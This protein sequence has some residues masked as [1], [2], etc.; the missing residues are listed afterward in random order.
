VSIN[1]GG[2]N[3]GSCT[4][5]FI[6]DFDG[7]KFSSET[8]KEDTLW[9]D[10]GP[11]NYA[12]VTW[13][14]ISANDGRRLFLGWMSNWSYAT[15]VPT[16][17]WR[18]AMTVPRELRLTKVNS[19]YYVSS[20]PAKELNNIVTDR[21]ENTSITVTDTLDLT[22][23]LGFDPSLSWIDIEMD[24][25]DF[26]IELSNTKGEKASISYDASKREYSFN[27]IGSGKTDFSSEF[28]RVS[29]APRINA[30]D[31]IKFSMIT[32][33]SSVEIFFDGGLTNLTGLFFPDEPF[34]RYRIISRGSLLIDRL[35]GRKLRSVWETSNTR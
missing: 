27:R 30:S 8:P 25:K 20:T 34:T 11:D 4:Q 31:K 32:D 13:S 6:G 15:I 18:S 22:K 35:E 14:N 24:A 28:Q 23:Q 2:P 16:S 7:Q 5:Y 33:V 26:T 10:Y 29:R 9:I 3:G 1:P 12:G 17:P 21:K 19:R